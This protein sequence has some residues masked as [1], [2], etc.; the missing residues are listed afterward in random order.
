MKNMTILATKKQ[1]QFKP[2]Q[3]QFWANIKGG[4]A[5]TKPNKP[6]SNPISNEMLSC[7][8]NAICYN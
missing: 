6:N 8:N 5:N 3:S 2:K 7:T 4:K 1:T